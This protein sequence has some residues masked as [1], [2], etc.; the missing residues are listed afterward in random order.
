MKRGENAEVF[1]DEEGYFSVVDLIQETTCWEGQ[2]GVRTRTRGVGQ[3]PRR[4]AR[5]RELEDS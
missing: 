2:G 1:F 3:G 5:T 4:N